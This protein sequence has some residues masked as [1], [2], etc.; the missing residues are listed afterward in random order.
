MET[1]L[2]DLRY[3]LRILRKSPGFT[4]IAVLTLALGI[5]ANTAI[6]SVLN[7][8]LLRPLPYHDPSRLV[9]VSNYLPRLKDTIVNT[10]DYIA[11]RD[12]SHSFS[13]LAAYDEDD[14][15]LSGGGYPERIHAAPVSASFFSLLG[16]PGSAPVVVLSHAFWQKHFSGDRSVIGQSVKLDGTAFE[17][18]GVMPAGFIFPT[19]GTKPELLVPLSLP[20]HVDLATQRIQIIRVIGRL[21]PGITPAQVKAELSTIDV[22][23]PPAM[24]AMG[25]G[26]KVQ[27]I[28]L[29]EKLAGKARPVLLVLLGAVVFLLLIACFNTANLQLAKATARGSELAVRA[30]LGASRYRLCRQLLS[31]SMLVSLLGGGAGALLAMWSIYALNRLHAPGLP[32]FVHINLDYRVLGFTLAVAVLTGILSGLTPAVFAYRADV[33]ETLKEGAQSHTEPRGFQLVRKLL[34]VSEVSLAAVLLVGSG[35]F[36]RSFVGLLYVDPGFDPHQL[37]T[38]RIALPESKY[39]DPVQQRA[40]FENLTQKLSALPGVT[41]AGAASDLPLTGFY[42]RA[43]SVIFEGRPAPPRGMRPMIPIENAT[44][45]YFRTIAAPLIVGRHLDST[46]TPNSPGVVLVNQAF[47][48]RFFDNEDPLGKRIQIGNESSWQTIVGI[49][50]DVRQM[51][52]QTDPSPEVFTPFQ[53]DSRAQMFVALRTAMNPAALAPA[54]RQA[55]LA[56]DKEQPTFDAATMEERLVESLAAQRWNMWLLAAFAS[57]ALALAAAGIYGVIAYF[58]VQRTHEIGVRMALGATPKSVLTLMLRQG[59][60]MVIL[61]GVIGIVASFGLTRFIVGMIY[62]VRVTDLVTYMSVS[63]LLAV[64]ALL[65]CY[66]PARRATRIDPM[67]ALRYE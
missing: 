48:R 41:Y 51:G 57:T 64:V 46:D 27:V 33:N 7:A 18:I 6:F 62:G 21:A 53:Q 31:E 8:V 4:A 13:E 65:A 56:L 23:Y 55:V 28:E 49:I 52:V 14:F 2:Q 10:P 39:P 54:V 43:S 58:V 5:G 11:W 67:V 44:T 24:K 42:T 19:D 16:A 32:Q 35:L 36:I 17:V 26:S 30:A 15:N 60:F 63:A 45:N 59:A 61:G 40:F 34:V 12:Q 37:L 3:G 9:W 47:C 20:E 25:Q 66:V 38:L 1:I 50:S 29:Q 22:G